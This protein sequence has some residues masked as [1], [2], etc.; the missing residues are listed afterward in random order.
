MKLL[1]VRQI[2]SFLHWGGKL[3]AQSLWEEDEDEDAS[4]EGAGAHDEEGERL[5]DGVEKGDLRRDDSS[6]SPTEG[7]A[8]HSGAP[9]LRGEE[10]C[11][12]HEH[13]GEAGGGS[14]LAHEG[15]SH[16]QPAEVVAGDEAGR[17]AGDACQEL[18]EGRLHQKFSK[19]VGNFHDLG[20]GV[21][22]RSF[23]RSAQKKMLHMLP[24]A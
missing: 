21:Q 2:E 4:N 17:D 18:T 24:K 8:S 10:L 5:P 9:D 14:E 3:L 19:I 12:V 15:E 1:F 7:A 20:R 22:G 13:D 16:L 6:D 23:S 11:R